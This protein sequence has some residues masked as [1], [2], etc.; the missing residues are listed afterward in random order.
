V[1]VDPALTPLAQHAGGQLGAVVGPEVLGSPALGREPLEH[2]DRLVGVDR[3]IDLDC[4]RLAGELVDDVE[5]L[6]LAPV[7]GGIVLEVKRPEM[8]RVGCAQATWA[9]YGQ[10]A[11]PAALALAH[12]HAQPLLTPDP[13]Y[14]LAVDLPALADQVA[15][16]AAVAPA[17]L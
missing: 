3:A 13:L 2:G 7:C 17:G 11:E 10:D 15:V 6:Q 16:G 14:A 5:E 1:A 12:G 8:A 9:I 4:E